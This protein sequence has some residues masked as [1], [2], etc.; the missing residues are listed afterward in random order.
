MG[1]KTGLLDGVL[2]KYVEIKMMAGETRTDRIVCKICG[3]V[4]RRG[5]IHTR[6]TRAGAW[7]YGNKYWGM[8]SKMVKHFH[9]HHPE[10]W[11]ALECE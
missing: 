11:A 4:V 7:G 9:Q 3:F 5:E 2:A 1:I 10:I 6:G 8:K